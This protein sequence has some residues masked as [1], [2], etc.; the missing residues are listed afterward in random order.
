MS[1]SLSKEIKVD[2]TGDG[3]QEPITLL[4]ELFTNR[5]NI[6]NQQCIVERDEQVDSVFRAITNLLVES[7]LT[8]H[9]DVITISASGH[10]NK[11]HNKDDS[12]S[13]E[14]ITINIYVKSYKEE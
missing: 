6:G 5:D 4:N 3:R 8:S 7:G 14:F 1:W 11:D 10:A 9:S 13:N 2:E 12:W